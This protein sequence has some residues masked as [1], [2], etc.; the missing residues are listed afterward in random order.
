MKILF[1]YSLN[2]IHSPE[3]RL[4]SY[5]EIQFGI[6][7]LSSYL[8]KHGHQTKLI[9]LSKTLGSRNWSELDTVISYF[10]PDVIGF[11]SVASE[12]NFISMMAANVKKAFPNIFLIIGGAHVSLNSEDAINA[13]F[14]AVCIGEGEHPMLELLD[15]L[16]EGAEPYG[17]N[18]IW[19]KGSNGIEK[20]PTRPFNSSI[21]EIPFPDRHLWKEWV[22]D[23]K[24]TKHAVL[25]ARG[26]P[27][28]C[29]FCSNHALRK[30]AGGS[31]VRHRSTESIIDEI[32]EITEDFPD[33]NSIYLEIETIGVDKKW[34]DDLCKKLQS[35]NRNIGRRIS[36]GVNLRIYPGAEFEDLFR[37]FRDSNIDFINIGLESG[38]EKIR[39][40]ILRRH[41]SN[42][43]IIRA[44]KQAKQFGIKVRLNNLLGLPEEKPEDFAMTVEVN[45]I[46]QPNMH[47]T[48][49]FYPYPGTDLYKYCDEKGLLDK[50][51]DTGIERTISILNMPYFSRNEIMKAYRWFAYNV[52]KGYKP[53]YLLLAKVF[54]SYIRA[55]PK[56]DYVFEP[57]YNS[58]LVSGIRGL[59]RRKYRQ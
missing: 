57:I 12:Y 19:L 58:S 1:V 29:T 51:S 22:A 24:G 3:K 21:D 28:K 48:N 23:E 53:T 10:N 37:E 18:N 32:T 27:Y 35:F 46:C 34:T 11:T 55:Y 13:D 38:S 6:S 36:Y 16:E 31:Y 52:Y 15:K 49:I 14:D 8:K 45:R 20:N 7:Y 43:D 26:C 5:G 56:I 59:L 47:A 41:Y 9:M 4:S 25:L 50:A 17:I 42:D 39:R 54:M 30:I 2:D 44:V 40:D 33:A